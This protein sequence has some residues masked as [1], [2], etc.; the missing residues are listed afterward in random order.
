MAK[1]A[2]SLTQHCTNHADCMYTFTH[3]AGWCGTKQKKRCKCHWC[4][5]MYKEATD[6]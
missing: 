4:A 1:K 2:I 5:K 3:T 6:G